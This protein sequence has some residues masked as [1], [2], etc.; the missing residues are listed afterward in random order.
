MILGTSASETIRDG[1]EASE[2][3]GLGGNDLLVGE[4]GDDALFGG[5]GD[6]RLNAG[7][8]DDLL[9]G[10]SGVNQLRGQ[11]GA[12][13]YAFTTDSLDGLA[14]QILAWNAT[15][16]DVIDISDI[17][18]AYGWSAAEA[19]SYVSFGTNGSN[20]T[21]ALN[22][23]DVAETLAELVGQGISAISLDDFVFV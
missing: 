20:A 3:I 8:G 6:D 4:G 19:E 2:I 13:T 7:D 1:N 17:S 11:A 10:G 14:D 22:A 15:S 9:V 18:A 12:D 16:G 21:I 23:P 5:L